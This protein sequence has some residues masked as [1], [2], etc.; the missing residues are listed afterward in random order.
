MSAMNGRFGKGTIVKLGDT[1][2]QPV[3]TTPTGC[4]PLDSAL[5]G[6]YPVGRVVEIFGPE[7]SGKTTLAL[8]AI[9]EAQKAGKACVFIDAEHALDKGYAKKLGV[10]VAQLMLVQPDCGEQALEVA[11][12]LARCGE[13]GMIVVDSVSALVPK[14]ELE[15]EIGTI[16][17]GAQARLMSS[18]LRKLCGSLAKGGT[19]LIFLN[20]IR[21]K[22]G[23]MYGNPEIT[24]GGNALKYYSSMRIDIRK[25]E[26]ITGEGGQVVG[27]KARAKVV[28]NKVG[29]PYRECNFDI[30]FGF[31][32]DELGALFEAAEQC[33]VVERKGSYYYFGTEK[34]SQGR[35]NAL[36]KIREDAALQQQLR[37]SIKE[38]LEAGEIDIAGAPDEDNPEEDELGPF[39]AGGE[40]EPAS[41][42]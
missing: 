21:L 18:A 31:G 2:Y 11:D 16:T 37:Q 28:K 8:H 34:L 25:K 22:V 12:Q 41:A 14:A 17:V 4:L 39:D 3:Q 38:K 7:S 13:I 40:F 15:G 19:T 30:R 24:S 27:V 36:A 29:V 9:A 1:S 33:G 6:G 26:N 20:Q 23:V 32:I 10:D 42:V 5:S 35:D